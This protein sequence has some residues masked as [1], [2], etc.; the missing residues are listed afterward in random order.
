MQPK[1]GIHQAVKVYLAKRLH[2][3]P[4]CSQKLESKPLNMVNSVCIDTNLADL[5]FHI[6]QAKDKTR[7][8]SNAEC[9]CA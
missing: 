9:I 5:S 8:V 3:P 2:F 6:S 4:V 7:T 1:A